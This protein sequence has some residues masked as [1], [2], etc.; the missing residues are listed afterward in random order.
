MLYREDII[1][2]TLT[3]ISIVWLSPFFGGLFASLIAPPMPGAAQVKGTAIYRA[4]IALT[5]DAVI[6]APLKDASKTDD[7]AL[8]VSSVRI[9]KP[10]QVPTQFEIPDDPPR[11]DQSHSYSVRAHVTAGQRL[12]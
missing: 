4:R 10:G 3:T 2:R 5:P 9:E 8:V 12:L 11:I 1:V 6:E 7:L